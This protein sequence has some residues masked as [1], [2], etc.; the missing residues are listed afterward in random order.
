MTKDPK[1]SPFEDVAEMA[2]N[3][4]QRGGHVFQKFTCAECGLRQTVEE[5]DHMFVRGQCEKCRHVTDLQ[6]QGC[7]FVYVG[8]PE[9]LLDHYALRRAK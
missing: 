5:P 6:V 9:I 8:R 7:G 4:V 2:W 3:L 1:D